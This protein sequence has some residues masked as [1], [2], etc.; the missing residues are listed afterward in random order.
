TAKM[1]L[2]SL[3]QMLEEESPP[4]DPVPVMLML[5]RFDFLESGKPQFERTV[6][7]ILDGHRTSYRESE[8]ILQLLGMMVDPW[9]YSRAFHTPHPVPLVVVLRSRGMG[10][11]FTIPEKLE[12]VPDFAAAGD[13]LEFAKIAH[14]AMLLDAAKWARDLEPWDNVIEGGRRIFGDRPA[15][16][17]LANTACGVR[18]KSTVS[19]EFGSLFER[20]KS[21]ANRA[22]YARQKGRAAAWWRS[23]FEIAREP[24]DRQLI[25]LL[26]FTWAG[27]DVIASLAE[28]ID[29]TVKTLEP[30]QWSW[31][32]NEIEVAL[33]RL[34]LRFRNRS[35]KLNLRRL[36]ES[37]DPKTAALI[38][39]RGRSEVKIAISKRYMRNYDGNDWTVL[40]CIQ[41]ATVFEMLQRP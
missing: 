35:F 13:C 19:D 39:L 36:P 27:A 28:Q 21:L 22:Q 9:M 38:A 11:G 34:E 3:L 4:V 25:T 23:H 12:K 26:L 14:A 40:E 8:S 31:L 29:E 37:L 7:S 5:H 6:D 2:N 24:I 16:L 32:S 18:S 1:D 41:I 30:S 10:Q 20:S 17:V 15:F 33:R